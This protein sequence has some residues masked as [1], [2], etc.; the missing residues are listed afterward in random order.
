MPCC[1]LVLASPEPCQRGAVLGS[2]HDQLPPAA[3]AAVEGD[4]LVAGVGVEAAHVLAGED[5]GG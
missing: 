3:A 5:G 4:V 1:R 2:E